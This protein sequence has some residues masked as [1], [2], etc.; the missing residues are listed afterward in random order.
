MTPQQ[1]AQSIAPTVIA[2]CL[3]TGV[4]PSV[5]IAQGIQESGS[6]SSPLATRFK[7][8]FGHMASA[9]WKG[10]TAQLVPGGKEWRVYNS[11]ADSI[12]AHIQVLKQTKY[13]LAGAF[14]AKTPADQAQALQN[15]GYNKGADRD[16]YAAK[17]T[18]IIKLYGLE[19]YDA[20]M[21]AM[22]RQKNENNLAYSEQDTITRHIHNL[23][24]S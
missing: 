4:F 14:A 1:F 20:Q 7:N 8:L 5:V 2:D 21:I 3:N 10:L 17:L 24:N 6:G 23:I 9:T 22:E 12:A 13:R 19:K 15:A 11:I 18:R 16:Q